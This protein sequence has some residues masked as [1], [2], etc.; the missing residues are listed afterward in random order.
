MQ[1]NKHITRL[2]KPFNNADETYNIKVKY[3]Y[4]LKKSLL[5]VYIELKNLLNNIGTKYN[6]LKI[7]LAYIY[8]KIENITCLYLF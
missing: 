8:L 5:C 1:V 6:C 2:I 7:L 3:D 4:C